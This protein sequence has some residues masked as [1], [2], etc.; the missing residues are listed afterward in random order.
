MFYP[1]PFRTAVV[2][3]STTVVQLP[4]MPSGKMILIKADLNNS[5]VV[6]LSS[7][8]NVNSSNPD[9]IPLSNSEWIYM[10][11]NNAN[12]IYAVSDKEDQKIY[13]AVGP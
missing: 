4:D 13:I 12:K 9:G 3:I 1:V 2:E 7:N 5:G 10:P 11:V 6:W 8:S